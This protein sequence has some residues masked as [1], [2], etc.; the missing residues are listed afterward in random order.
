MQAG[1][2]TLPL[3]PLTEVAPTAGLRAD[4]Q[5]RYLFIVLGFVGLVISL[6]SAA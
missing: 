6:P 1:I 3:Q 2:D 4:T 5:A